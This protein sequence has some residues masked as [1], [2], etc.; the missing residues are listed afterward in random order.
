MDAGQFINVGKL[1][2][3]ILND[4]QVETNNKEVIGVSNKA[5]IIG[6]TDADRYAFNAPADLVKN[7]ILFEYVSLTS[8]T[9]HHK[10]FAKDYGTL[11]FGS[12]STS[13]ST[14][15]D[16]TVTD[17]KSALE[18]W[19]ANGNKL[20]YMNS[21][22]S[23]KLT[24]TEKDNTVSEVDI[25]ELFGA[26]STTPIISSPSV[27]Y[28]RNSKLKAT[29]N[30]E[31]LENDLLLEGVKPTGRYSLNASGLDHIVVA[32]DDERSDIPY[33]SMKPNKFIYVSYGG[34][35][36]GSH[37]EMGAFKYVDIGL[38]TKVLWNNQSKTKLAFDLKENKRI[39]A[40]GVDCD[41]TDEP[42]AVEPII[43]AWGDRP[44]ELGLVVHKLSEELI[45]YYR[46]TGKEIVSHGYW[47]H[48]SGSIKTVTENHVIPDG[49]IITLKKPYRP[50]ISEVKIG[51]T[52]LTSG[53]GVLDTNQYHFMR[54][55]FIRFN[56]E[57]QGKT[58]T[59][60]YSHSE[61]PKEWIGSIVELN[62]IGLISKNAVCLTGESYSVHPMTY[63]W[64]RNN[65]VVICDMSDFS[66]RASTLLD[67][68][69]FHKK[70]TPWYGTSFASKTYGGGF[71]HMFS[72]QSELDGKNLVFDAIDFSSKHNQPFVWYTHDFY[73]AENYW[74]R[75]FENPDGRF[76]EWWSDY[77]L[78]EVREIGY[79][80]MKF[81]LDAIDESEDMYW[82]PR[83]DYCRRFEN[84]IEGINYTSKTTEFGEKL[85]IENAG[86]TI[87]GVTFRKKTSSTPISVI[88]DGVEIPH[89][90]K[91]SELRFSLDVLSGEYIE[92]FINHS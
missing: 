45:D 85:I 62:N 69:S 22:N 76:P 2:E 36:S 57:H 63:S 29:T 84:L 17:A 24:K 43:K 35:I 53:S 71:D 20:I 75:I 39:V 64:A 67:G 19:L 86:K 77:T 1:K 80:M 31:W 37:E 32:E 26:D 14:L 18:F 28:T 34:F 88:R 68:V 79:E 60:T 91:N 54:Y 44:L 16:A 73:F 56:P 65:N 89:T 81:W 21:A 47:H 5:L 83:S 87:D 15:S 49:N 82:M 50:I 9:L 66:K 72:A 70:L 13:L 4:V 61:E 23:L 25:S 42:D 92:V 74:V 30:Y 48:M 41:V 38:L 59:L 27:A 10:E 7:G 78:D 40:A 52:T 8:F 6:Q 90:F 12:Y 46:S 51:S 3:D 33:V 55:G 58:V 11:I